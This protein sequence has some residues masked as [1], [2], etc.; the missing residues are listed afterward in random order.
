MTLGCWRRLSLDSSQEPS[1]SRGRFRQQRE[2]DHG[3]GGRGGHD[4]SRSERLAGAASLRRRLVLAAVHL[5]VLLEVAALG[6]ALPTLVAL[7][8]ALS[9]VRAHVGREDTL[10]LERLVANR[11]LL[12]PVLRVC[13]LVHPQVAGLSRLEIATRLRADVRLQVRVHQ[14]VVVELALRCGGRG[15]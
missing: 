2:T 7:V 1:L 5:L 4:G 10:R 3:C 13:L 8:R 6:K 15:G 12:I 11:A 14:L 9:S